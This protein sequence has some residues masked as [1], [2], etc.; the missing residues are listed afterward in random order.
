MLS[1]PKKALAV[2]GHERAC[3][4]SAKAGPQLQTFQDCFTRLLKGN[5]PIG[6]AFEVFN[7]RY[8]EISSD[9]TNQLEEIKFSYLKT[10]DMELDRQWTINN[11]AR[12][13]V[14]LGDPAVRLA[15]GKGSTEDDERP[16]IPEI[17]RRVRSPHFIRSRRCAAWHPPL[18]SR[19]WHR[20]GS[21]TSSGSAPT[22][23]SSST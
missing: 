5:Y 20:S 15:V 19:S 1:L 11:D 12:N 22:P 17:A 8:A 3:E 7:N 16:T 6:Y 10:N 4:S 14:V 9:L 18:P 23:C 21:S 2:V 13:Y